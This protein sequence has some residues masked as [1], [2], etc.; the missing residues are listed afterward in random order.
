MNINIICIG[1][2]KEKYILDGIAEFS[3][4]MQAFGKFKII[5]LKEFGNDSDR[6]TSIEK[7]SKSIFETLE[8]NKGYNILLDIQGKNISSEEMAKEIEN[9]CIKGYSTINFIIGGSYGVSDELKKESDFRLSF[10]KMTFPH[11]LM[12]LILSEQIYRW[13]SIINNIKYHK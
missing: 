4:R 11:Q 9:I 1:K 8:K 3:K 10:S 12:R 5:E 7:E 13:F 2:V 6:S